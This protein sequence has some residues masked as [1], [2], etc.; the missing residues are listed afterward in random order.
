M[1]LYDPSLKT[2]KAYKFAKP[3]RNPYKIVHLLKG[4]AEI[5]LVA[6]PKSHVA[7]NQL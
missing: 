7:F 1:F 2:G 3:F 6:K 4:G 5:Q